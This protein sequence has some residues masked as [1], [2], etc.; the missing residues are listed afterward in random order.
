MET[1]QT[2]LEGIAQ[3]GRRLLLPD[4]TDFADVL[5]YLGEYQYRDRRG[6]SATG[7]IIGGNIVS[8][9][10]SVD[11]SQLEG[12]KHRTIE[13]RP[14]ELAVTAVAP[15]IVTDDDRMAW[16]IIAHRD[17]GLALVILEHG[18]IIGSHWVAYIDPATIPA[19]S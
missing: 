8:T 10:C 14:T 16:K 2:A 6:E 9:F 13:V 3:S 17:T 7:A 19:A 15:R 18:Q 4:V 5:E 1:R 11:L 12:P